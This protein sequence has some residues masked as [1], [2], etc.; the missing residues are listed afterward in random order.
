MDRARRDRVLQ[1]TDDSAQS[2]S[3]RRVAARAALSPR[4]PLASSILIGTFAALAITRAVGC[5]VTIRGIGVV[6]SWEAGDPAASAALSSVNDSVRA[7]AVI[8][9]PLQVVAMVGLVSWQFHLARSAAVDPR[10]LR[11]GPVLH[12]VSYVIPVLRLWWPLQN[13]RDTYAGATRIAS[14]HSA[15]FPGS[16]ERMP[17]WLLGWWGLHVLTNL[18]TL[19]GALFSTVASGA[20]EI[21]QLL[22]VLTVAFA[23]GVPTA[24]AAAYVVWRI[25]RVAR[26]TTPAGFSLNA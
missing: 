21:R 12:L 6:R 7:Y 8:S 15:S 16:V 18:L 23:V 4:F 24:V 5:L 11:R 20:M 19:L 9:G 1:P 26:A 17:P 13:L 25:S 14:R 3:A 10:S 2:R 22:A